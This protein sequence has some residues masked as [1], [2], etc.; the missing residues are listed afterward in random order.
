MLILHSIVDFVFSVS[1]ISALQDQQY[2]RFRLP[3]GL[4]ASRICGLQDQ[5]SNRLCPLM[6]TTV[7]SVPTEI[8]TEG[9]WKLLLGVFP[10]F[11]LIVLQ[12][13]LILLRY[14]ANSSFGKV[15]SRLFGLPSSFGKVIRH[16][17]G[18]LVSYPTC[19]SRM[20]HEFC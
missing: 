2:H 11:W 7:S 6:G 20:C 14:L 18:Y 12:I 10:S 8:L 13:R 5:Q 15:I 16:I 1:P 17:F 9:T 19:H 4:F 3:P